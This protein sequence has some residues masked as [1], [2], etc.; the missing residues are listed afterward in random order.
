MHRLPSPASGRGAAVHSPRGACCAASRCAQV[1]A[2]RCPSTST[3]PLAIAPRRRIVRTDAVRRDGA[4]R[5]WLTLLGLLFIP[6]LAG[7]TTWP[8][9]VS[10]GAL[11][12]VHLTPGSE[13]RVNDKPVRVGADG[14]AVFGVGR[15]ANAPLQLQSSAPDG[16][17]DTRSIAVVPR[18]WPIERVSGVPPQTVNPPPAVAARIAR[19]QAQVA[20]ARQR[21]DDREDFLGPFIWPV[22]GRVSGRFGN[23]RIY[24]GEPRAPHS[25]MDIAVPTGT[26]VVAPAAG[27]V[28]F[29]QPDLYLTGGTVL[30]DHG[31]GLSS[32]FLH[33]SKLA[34]RV[35]QRVQ[36]GQVIGRSGMSGRASGPHLHWGFNWF[37]VRLDPLLLPGIR[38]P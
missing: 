24:N 34:V 23:Q 16:T 36:Q 33:L 13:L 4:S 1:A 14:V 21:D 35:G 5:L 17:R 10:Q 12:I 30:I 7:A 38:A 29:A 37:G 28:T 31:F 8:E 19:E 11:V 9:R 32:N 26:P 2:I 6:A 25:G 3:F 22:H 20:T 15:D 18:D 27:I